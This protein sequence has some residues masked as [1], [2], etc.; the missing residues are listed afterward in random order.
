MTNTPRGPV[1]PNRTNE[2]RAW[3]GTYHR[4]AV[5]DRALDLAEVKARL[6]SGPRSSEGVRKR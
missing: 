1:P 5:Y 2:D 4:V 6:E 3:L